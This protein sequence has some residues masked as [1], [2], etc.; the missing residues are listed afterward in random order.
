M[1]PRRRSGGQA[2][3]GLLLILVGAGLFVQANFGVRAREIWQYW[4]VLPLV[5]GLVKLAFGQSQGERVIGFIAALW[6]SSQLSKLLGYWSPDSLD[7]LAG[8]LI[9]GGAS[10]VYRGLVGRREPDPRETAA[11]WISAISVLSGV[12][13][14]SNAQDF[15]GGDLTALMGGCEIDLRRASMSAPASF[16]VFVLWGG[17][18]IRVP[19]DWT[20]DLRGQPI[21]G[22][23]VDS[24]R[25]PALATEKRLVIRGVVLMGGL[26]IKN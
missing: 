26:E 3:A 14:T 22:G 13:R 11:D 18:E 21:M 7:V 20:V 8:A 24:T 1:R 25:P 15:R 17:I 19:D 9:A 10:F 6:G 4:P 5:I 16:D 12:K 2:V 23:F